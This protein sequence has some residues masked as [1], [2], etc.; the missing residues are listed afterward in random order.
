MKLLTDDEILQMYSEPRSDAEMLEFA[1][2]VEAAVIAK[3]NSQNAPETPTAALIDPK[4]LTPQDWHIQAINE[5]TQLVGTL[6]YEQKMVEARRYKLMAQV[7][8]TYQN[9]N[10]D[11][12]T[13]YDIG[14]SDGYDYAKE[15]RND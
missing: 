3:I 11:T 15:Y 2:E 4:L 14:F 1:R 13:A 10:T 9:V 7:M 6:E 8:E 5:A 12:S